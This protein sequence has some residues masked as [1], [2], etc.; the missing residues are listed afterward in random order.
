MIS[1]IGTER[2]SVQE[3]LLRYVYEIGW[4]YIKP[5]DVERFRG[6]RTG[7]IL[8]EIFTNQMLKLNEDF[9]DNHMI[10]DLIKRIERLSPSIEG[11]LKMWEYLKGLKTVYV[12]QEKRERNVKLIDENPKNNVYHVT[13]EFSFTN[14]KYTNR[15]DV[16]FFINGIPLFF[17]ETKAAHKLDGIAEALE[18]VKRYHKETPKAMTVFQVYIL[19]HLI[20]FYYSATWNFS[21]KSIFSWKIETG[22]KQFEK[23]VKEFFDKKRVIQ[24]VLDYILFTRKDDELQKVV[25]RPH[26]MRAIH[27]VIDR[28]RDKKKTRGLIWHTQGSGKTYSMIV[29]AKKI[30]ESPEFENPTVIMLVDRNELESQ[31]FSNLKSVGFEHVSVAESKEHLRQMLREDKRGLIVTMIHKFE[32]MP[33]NINTRKNI[34]V[35]VDEAHRTTGGDLGNYLMG[36]LPNA[37]YIGFTGTPIDKTSH[38]KGTFEIFGRDDLPHGYLDKYGIAESIE[39]G[40]TVKLHYALASNELLPDKETLEKEFLNLK[41]AEGICDIELL[42]KVLDKAVTLKNM[43]KSP[44]RIKKVTEYIVNHYKNNVEPLGYKAFIV[45][46]DREACAL[47]K[48][49]LDKHLPKEY[50]EVVISP[51]QNDSDLLAKYH[52]SEEKEKQIRKAFIKPDQL[53]KILIVTE[54]LLTGFDA[55]ILYCMYLDKPMRDHVLLQ[56]IARVNRPYEDQKGIKKPCGLVIDF[57]GIFD[58]LEKALSFDSKDIS[59]VVKDINVLKS[60]FAEMMEI[61]KR[62]YLSIIKAKKADKAVEAILTHFMDEE[63]RKEFY[64]FYDELSDMYEIISPDAFLRPY[65]EDYDTLSRMSRIIKDAYEPHLLIDKEFARKTAKLVQEHTGIGKIKA[66]LDIYE[67]NEETLRKLE[68]SPVSDTEK[69]F[70]LLK[71]IEK[72]IIEH[73]KDNP[74]LISIGERV[75]A[76]ASSF[77]QRQKDTKETLESLKSIIAEINLAKKERIEKNMSPD[78]FTVYWIL[79]N[80][81]IEQAEDIARQA[82]KL[83]NEYPH[84]KIS[85]EQERELKKKLYKIIMQAI[86]NS[87]KQIT[88]IGKKILTI[89]KREFM[90]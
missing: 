26:Q 1:K 37:T 15:Y 89:L 76:I 64:K 56:A 16:V 84:W 32:G 50:S 63:R 69:I 11:N 24:I 75:E 13:D 58:K 57:I 14:D 46:V 35:L 85:E 82:E 31:L 3:P 45:A 60:R 22:D 10:D 33:A 5:E 70:N 21:A 34:F 8:R 36:A 42:N 65:L 28:A 71:S 18:Q 48:E 51:A 44:E 19:T 79:K 86:R 52:L 38:G 40:T 27:K 77:K 54:K 9:I 88:D 2:Y 83:F 80:E 41:E 6:G 53:P 73:A 68:Q 74:Y 17:A 90:K 67:I 29:A 59:D 49:E 20:Q 4:E 47:Y 72:E 43:L 7:L 25:L 87:S 61:A 30:M 55:P 39:D 23:L 66:Q 81:K 12:P 62:E 78:V